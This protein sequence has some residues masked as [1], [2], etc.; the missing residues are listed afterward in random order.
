MIIE[1][2]KKLDIEKYSKEETIKEIKL[3]KTRLLLLLKKLKQIRSSLK[4]DN[5]KIVIEKIVDDKENK[6]RFIETF[7]DANGS[8]FK[9]YCDKN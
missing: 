8:Y 5:K 9:E 4:S 6:D 3:R 2:P 1:L 7:S